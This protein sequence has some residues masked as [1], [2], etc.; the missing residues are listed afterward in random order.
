M[1]YY[2]CGNAQ[3]STQNSLTDK[4]LL[5]KYFVVFSATR[6]GCLLYHHPYAARC[7]L[8]GWWDWSKRLRQSAN[9]NGIPPY[10]GGLFRKDDEVDNLSLDDE[11][12]NFFKNIGDYDFQYEVNVDVLG[13]LFEKSI[14]DIERIRLGGLFES[15]GI[16][17]TF[18]TIRSDQ[19]NEQGMRYE[20]L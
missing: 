9:I 12:T 7:A 19:W 20:R 5:I 13:H 1:I 17:L 3:T 18:T 11:W 10:N 4:A 8:V 2:N 14:N 6:S 15:I 16:C